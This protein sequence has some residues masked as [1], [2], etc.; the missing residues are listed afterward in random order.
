MSTLL[1]PLITSEVGQC[2]PY[3]EPWLALLQAAVPVLH[4]TLVLTLNLTLNLTLTLILILTLCVLG[5][6]KSSNGMSPA[7]IRSD[8]P[9]NITNGHVPL[10][11]QVNGESP[12]LPSSSPP[13]IHTNGVNNLLAIE[14]EA[15]TLTRTL[16]RTLTLTLI[17]TVTSCTTT[18]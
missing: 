5:A 14:P 6:V 18:T 7:Y 13:E 8:Q 17:L 3:F 4:L 16:T 1:R 10:T 2:L 12:L 11:H 9:M 15:G